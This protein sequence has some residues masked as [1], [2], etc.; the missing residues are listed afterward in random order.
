M[1][2]IALDGWQTS[3]LEQPRTEAMR[4]IRIDTTV[5]IPF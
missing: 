2:L 1:R 5:G 4:H 3:R